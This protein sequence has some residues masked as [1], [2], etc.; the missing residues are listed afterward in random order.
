MGMCTLY[1][2]CAL[3]ALVGSTLMGGWLPDAKPGADFKRQV[4]RWLES[5]GA[6][7]GQ[8]SSLLRMR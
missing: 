7:L 4:H 8:S 6:E 3:P 1:E 2:G 5:V